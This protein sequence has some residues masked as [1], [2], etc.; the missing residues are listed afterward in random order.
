MNNTDNCKVDAPKRYSLK[1]PLKVLVTIYS[2]NPYEDH[3]ELYAELL[4]F[5]QSGVKL[6]APEEFVDDR[7]IRVTIAIEE[8]GLQFHVIGEVCWCKPG[9]DQKW[10]A[11]C[12]LKPGIPDGIFD[13]LIAGGL[14]DRRRDERREDSLYQCYRRQANGDSTRIVLQNY[15]KGGLCVV[16]ET[17]GDVGG[18]LLLDL[19][20]PS[21]AVIAAKIQWQIEAGKVYILGCLLPKPEDNA[22]LESFI[23]FHRKSH[24]TSLV[25]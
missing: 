14:R 21:P 8:I 23:N 13:R 2:G 11:G 3:K 1:E 22:Q 25:G 4:D 9:R 15:S 20:E 12:K 17:P 16:S 5:S 7:D 18:E 24:E 19:R 6:I 10:L